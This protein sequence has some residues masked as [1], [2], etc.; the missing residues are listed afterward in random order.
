MNSFGLKVL[1]AAMVGWY[2][3]YFTKDTSTSRSVPSLALC[4]SA[5]RR[6]ALYRVVTKVSEEITASIFREYFDFAMD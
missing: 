3:E 5:L 6:N 1:S 2:A 4:S